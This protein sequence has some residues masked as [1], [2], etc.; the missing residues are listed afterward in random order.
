MDH[1]VGFFWNTGLGFFSC[2]Q[3]SVERKEVLCFV[4]GN[5][6][7]LVCSLLQK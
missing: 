7:G 5:E 4:L 6:N 1:I 3:S 2:L